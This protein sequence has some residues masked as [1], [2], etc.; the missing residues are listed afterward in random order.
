LVVHF[1]IALAL[2]G[3]VLRVASL[4]LQKRFNFL[5][6]AAMLLILAGTVASIIAAKSGID[7]HGRAEH[8]P[9]CTEVVLAHEQWGLRARNLLL[10]VSA[11]EIVAFVLARRSKDKGAAMP[12]VIATALSALVGLGGGFAIF[13]AGQG[14]GHLV[15]SYAGGVGVRGKDPRDVARLLLAGFFH[16]A[17]VER[18]AGNAGAAFAVTREMGERFPEDVEVQLLVA[19]SLIVDK[20]DADAALTKLAQCD[21]G[22]AVP[23][24]KGRKIVLQADALELKG[25]KDGA[26]S[27]LES[28]LKAMPDLRS[29]K[30][31]LDALQGASK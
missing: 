22:A 3:V 17:A 13:R 27:A 23:R 12:V 21:T 20:K 16:Q 30:R 6:P 14:G 28:G 29:L 25:D 19:E 11:L 26:R 5:S 2:A 9:G 18:E 1:A 31:R 10:A 7:A 24:I 4:G 15:Y 8:V